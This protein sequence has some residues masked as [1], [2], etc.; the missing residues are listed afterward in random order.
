MMDASLAQFKYL[1]YKINHKLFSTFFYNLNVNINKITLTL[2]S[3]KSQE[4]HAYTTAE[5]LNKYYRVQ[6]KKK[7]F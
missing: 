2:H 7:K 4:N 5:I 6:K 3:T 1:N